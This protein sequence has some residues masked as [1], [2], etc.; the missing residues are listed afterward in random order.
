MRNSLLLPN[1]HK[2]RN[3]PFHLVEA[4]WS[5]AEEWNQ[6]VAE[7]LADQENLPAE[8]VILLHLDNHLVEDNHHKVDNHQKNLDSDL[9]LILLNILSKSVDEVIYIFQLFIISNK[10]INW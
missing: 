2:L 9:H 10:F 6:A 4:E 7:N 1:H 8:V 3:H 5:P